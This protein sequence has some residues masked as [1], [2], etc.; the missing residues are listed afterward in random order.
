MGKAKPLVLVVAVVVWVAV[1]LY[2][3]REDLTFIWSLTKFHDLSEYDERLYLYGSDYVAIDYLAE[4]A[5]ESAQILALV[6]DASYF[7][8][9][10]YFLYPRKITVVGDPAQLSTIAQSGDFDYL[11][12][13]YPPDDRYWGVIKAIGFQRDFGWTLEKVYRGLIGSLGEDIVGTPGAMMAKLSENY[14]NGLYAIG[15][16]P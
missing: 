15:E 10:H 9:F 14:G 13:Y 11:Y 7:G 8:K 1:G 2:W 16:N 4:K 3:A 6:P 12:V 5:S